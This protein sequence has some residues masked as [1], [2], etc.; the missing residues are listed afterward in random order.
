MLNLVLNILDIN[1]YED[2]K[3]ELKCNSTDINDLI[4]SVTEDLRA[5][6]NYKKL[7]INLRLQDD[8]IF[9]FDKDIIRRVLDNILNNAIKFS[10]T[11]ETIHISTIKDSEFIRVTVR[12]SGL[13]IPSDMQE[14]IFE[15][16]GRV[17]RPENDSSLKSTGL[18]LTFCKMAIMAHYGTIGVESSPGKPTDFWFTLPYRVE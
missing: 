17:N 2:S 1:K 9:S 14:A 11:N 3:L 8:L 7:N 5:T 15:P 6:L 10:P 12:N 13:A 4:K 16:Y 18:G